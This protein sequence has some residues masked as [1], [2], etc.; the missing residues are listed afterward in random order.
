MLKVK[1]LP[2]TQL[3]AA[4]ILTF[5]LIKKRDRAN[6]LQTKEDEDAEKCI[7][8]LKTFLAMGKQYF[9]RTTGKDIDTTF[10]ISQLDR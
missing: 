7:F 10:L 1:K 3:E 6:W 2:E 9:Q 4:K 8:L 5:F